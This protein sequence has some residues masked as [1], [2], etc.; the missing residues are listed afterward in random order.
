MERSTFSIFCFIECYKLIIKFITVFAVTTSVTIQILILF[1][2]HQ[3][4]DAGDLESGVESG[5]RI[6]QQVFCEGA[7]QD[8]VMLLHVHN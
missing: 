4:P 5:K 7:T 2:V 6:L 1:R 3:Q 8:F